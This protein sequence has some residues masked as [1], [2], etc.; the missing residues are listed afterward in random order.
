MTVTN[1]FNVR[2]RSFTLLTVDDSHY[3]HIA[4]TYPQASVKGLS[5]LVVDANSFIV[6]ALYHTMVL[7][8]IL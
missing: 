2:K 3:T 1:V 7:L 4:S 5:T 6:S 8:N